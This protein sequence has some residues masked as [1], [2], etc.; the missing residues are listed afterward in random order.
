[1]IRSSNVY[2]AVGPV[3][4]AG[5][6]LGTW[7]APHRPVM[8]G[9]LGVML[10]VGALGWWGAAA[11]AR[12]RARVALQLSGIVANLACS[13]ALGLLAG[14][15]ASPL[16]ALIPFS[17]IFFATLVPPRVFAAVAALG[18]IAYWT[19]VLFGDPAPPGYPVVHTLGFGGMAYLCLRH[20]S[21]LASLR[22]RLAELSRVDPLTGC[23][24][25]RGF[26]ERL[27]QELA[28]G[29]R[30]GDPVT[31]VLVDLDRFKE[32]NDAHGHR[33]GDEVL[34]WAGRTLTGELR[35]HDTVGRLGGDEFA[36]ILGDTGPDG[37]AIL[38]ERLR[39]AIQSATPA[40]FGHASFPADASTVAELKH[41]ADERLYADKAARDRQV[42]SADSVAAA[43]AQ[44]ERQVPAVVSRRER[45][46]HSIADAG[47]MSVT[48]AAIAL[49][50][51]A[52]FATDHP[53]RF[54]MA[55]LS[56]LGGALGLAVLAAADWLSRAT[57]ARTVMGVLAAILLALNAGC[58][59][60]NG[61]VSS[62]TGVGLL[63]TM[64]LLAL[65]TRARVVLPVLG[66]AS[67]LYLGVA[68][69]AGASSGWYVATDL[70][71][72]L[73]AALAC[74]LQGWSA[75]RQRALVSR[76]SSVDSLTGCLNRRGFEDRFT[77]EITHARRTGHPTSLL[78]LDLDGFKQLNDSLGHAAGDDLLCWVGNTLRDCVHPHDIVGRL[79]GDE[80]VV[81]VGSRG[82]TDAV[83]T[84][85][86]AAL[87]VR[88]P[89]SIGAAALGYD[90]YD[91]D[92]L[93]AAADARLY[94]EKAR[95]RGGHRGAPSALT[96]TDA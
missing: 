66:T 81:L 31:L 39:A 25:R 18:L 88:T 38:A 5:Y 44:V 28:E 49:F 37:T 8:L 57:A 50:Y 47:R 2:G 46:R 45:R 53:H 82:D 12:S 17:L 9:V 34:A 29:A 79:G 73:A 33:A 27:E 71:G 43:R 62:P 32:V 55:A 84:R 19:V 13:A 65:G 70:A 24:N 95:R 30:T 90:G 94:G 21:V 11:I 14:G 78:I 7:D 54:G 36:V 15:V 77:A 59:A 10:A 42:P 83:V 87:A 51:V 63:L 3:L 22:R 86:R 75:A 74:A 23:L 58:A 60:F 92:S 52:F 80:F 96:P 48:M 93:Y 4:A 72:G 20:A 1:V 85:L 26:D 40:S 69:F 16:G 56:T 61:G 67:L 6:V 35:A 89:V 68:V 41:I 91:F 76:L 64:P